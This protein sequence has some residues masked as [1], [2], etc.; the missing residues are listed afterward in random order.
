MARLVV[1]LLGG[2]RV[3]LDGETIYGFETDKARALLAYLIVEA[4]R[5]H[6]RE[7]LAG[8]LWPERP[9]AAARNSLRH[10]VFRVRQALTG[11]AAPGSDAPARDTPGHERAERESGSFLFVSPMEI[12][13]NTACDYSLDVAELDALA[14]HD[15]GHSPA[16]GLGRPPQLLPE[17]FCADFLAGFSVP[18]SEAFEEWVLNKQFKTPCDWLTGAGAPWRASI[19]KGEVAAGQN[20]R[21]AVA[22]L[23]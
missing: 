19:K 11:H 2:F 16:G 22:V 14:H 8:L 3:E 10:T 5:P 15:A 21:A 6:R 12:Q 20:L 18:D 4:G 13:F 23:P 7:T 1:H 9:D 17:A